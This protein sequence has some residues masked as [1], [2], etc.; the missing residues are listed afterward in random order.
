MGMCHWGV[1]G[2]LELG[3]GILE[4][5]SSLNDSIKDPSPAAPGDYQVREPVLQS[6]LGM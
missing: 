1:D 6:G 5:I 2:Q 4:V 3:W